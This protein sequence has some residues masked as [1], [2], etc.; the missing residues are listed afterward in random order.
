MKQTHKYPL[1]VDEY[2]ARRS[3]SSA[4]I[5]PRKHHTIDKTLEHAH[6]LG[7]D[8]I[9]FEPRSVRNAWI[10]Q[11]LSRADGRLVRRRLRG[12]ILAKNSCVI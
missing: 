3:D 4:S 1:G 9:R 12:R 7:V 11:F 10:M 6:E 2:A 8:A 5:E